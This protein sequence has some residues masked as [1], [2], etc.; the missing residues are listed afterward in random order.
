MTSYSI[1]I[2]LN[3]IKLGVIR[4]PV[5]SLNKALFFTQKN[6]AL[7]SLNQ[8]SAI[9]IGRDLF[10]FIYSTYC[11]YKNKPLVFLYKMSKQKNRTNSF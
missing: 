10:Y 3:E 7:T 8:L 4:K 6:L 2:I 5:I 1:K 9:L 11:S